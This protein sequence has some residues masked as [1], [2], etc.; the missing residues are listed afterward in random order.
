MNLMHKSTSSHR[1]QTSAI[2]VDLNHFSKPITKI[3]VLKAPDAYPCPQYSYCLQEISIQWSLY[4]GNDMWSTNE[5]DGD[6]TVVH[7]AVKIAASSPSK[8]SS[9]IVSYSPVTSDDQLTPNKQLHK[10][11]MQQTT[12]KLLPNQAGGRIKTKYDTKSLNWIVRGARTRDLD[13]CIELM[14]HKIK[15]K[16]DVYDPDTLDHNF[17]YRIALGVC[18]I[19][20]R[21]KLATSAFNM[22]L[23]RYESDT[24]PKHTNSNM[25]FMKMLCSRTNDEQNL[26]EC[27]L[28]LSIQPLRF[29]IDQDALLFLIDY[30][31]LLSQKEIKF[32]GTPI[33]EQRSQQ[34]QHATTTATGQQQT[35]TPPQPIPKQ[36]FIKNFIFSPDLFIRFDFSGKYDKRTDRKLDRLTNLLMFMVQLSNTEIKLKK[37]YYKRGFLGL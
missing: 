30:F 23:Y 14:C 31:T 26:I 2:V 35:T 36:I 20:I 29:N 1:E 17:M 33:V 21:D 16:I 15:C 25:I 32:N 19:E 24:C 8:R 7:G 34:Q 12:D 37:V 18:D 10:R 28:K 9:S 3:D 11:Q 27:D 4:G 13:A 5:D 22:F 6:T